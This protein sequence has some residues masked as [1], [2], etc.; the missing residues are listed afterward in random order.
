MVGNEM[1]DVKN[2]RSSID[3]FVK[4]GF[5]AEQLRTVTQSHR[6]CHATVQEKLSTSTLPFYDELPY[7]RGRR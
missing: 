6:R 3:R 7:M 1:Y 2:I 4:S 5:K